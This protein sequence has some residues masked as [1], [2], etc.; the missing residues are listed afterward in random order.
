VS[1]TDKPL[2]PVMRAALLAEGLDGGPSQEQ[3]TRMATKLAGVLGISA[4]SLLPSGGGGG[5]GGGGS[6]GGGSAAS[7]ATTAAVASK[8]IGLVLGALI[9]G[10]AIG[11][12]V[13]ELRPRAPAIASV[14]I[15]AAV[16][17]APLDG[18]GDATDATDAGDASAPTSR[19]VDASVPEIDASMAPRPR[20]DAGV[21]SADAGVAVSTDALA[22]ERQLIDVARSALRGGDLQLAAKTLIE[23]G[24]RFPAG[25]LVEEQRVLAIELAVAKGDSTDAKRRA[26]AFRRDYPRSVFRSRVDAVVP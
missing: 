25:A 23:H 6:D 19:H 2:D 3:R 21:T 13:S 7:T 24:L 22:R 16:T 9:A 26:D 1:E 8:P 4:A 15:D 14:A 5:S 18:A 17:D 10:G 20:A 12:A 11:V